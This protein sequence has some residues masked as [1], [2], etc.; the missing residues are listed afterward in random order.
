MTHILAPP[1]SS[2]LPFDHLKQTRRS[3]FKTVRPQQRT[4][5]P[6]TTSAVYTLADQPLAEMDTTSQTGM[7][8]SSSV[9]G[10][11]SHGAGGPAGGSAVNLH[12]TAAAFHP[13]PNGG[14][15]TGVAG[16][17]ADANPAAMS[18]K[19][20]GGTTAMSPRDE[21]SSQ[22]GSMNGYALQEVAGYAR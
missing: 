10:N 1:L 16:P 4:E 13:N 3:Y 15:A 18:R 6:Q 8:T 12:P 9:A 7:A 19:S 17:G 14:Y 11:Y 22:A 21:S 5:D 2:F 20:L